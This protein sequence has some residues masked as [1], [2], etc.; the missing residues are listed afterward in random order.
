MSTLIVVPTDK[1][2]SAQVEILQF[3]MAF[4]IGGENVYA[5]FPAMSPEEPSRHGSI[6]L[7]TKARKGVIRNGVARMESKARNR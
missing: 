6:S 5:Q 1:P 3:A 4:H 7:T 2:V